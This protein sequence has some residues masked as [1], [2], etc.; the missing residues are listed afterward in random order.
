MAS[1]VSAGVPIR[2]A[3]ETG[4]QNGLADRGLLPPPL[5]EQGGE[6][7]LAAQRRRAP[8]RQQIAKVMSKLRKRAGPASGRSRPAARRTSLRFGAR[9]ADDRT[10]AGMILRSS[11]S[12]PFRHPP[13]HVG[14]VGARVL[15]R[16]ADGVD[17]LG[18]RGAQLAPLLGRRPAITDG[19]AACRR[20]SADLGL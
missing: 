11:G 5:D 9:A 18:G 3:G 16:A 7:I 19:L 17:D 12:R 1:A 4:P 6:H 2:Q 8:V 15:E 13:L 10:S 14:V 20:R